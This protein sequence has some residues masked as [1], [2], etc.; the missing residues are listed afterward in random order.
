MDRGAD[1]VG[2]GGLSRTG[3][4]GRSGDRFAPGAE[5]WLWVCVIGCSCLLPYLS[6]NFLS[7]LGWVHLLKATTTT[8]KFKD[9]LPL[10][11]HCFPFGCGKDARQMGGKGGVI[12]FK[13]L[14]FAVPC[15]LGSPVKE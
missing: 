12:G 3:I 7:P 10:P 6:G 5:A 2:M 4:P 13:R 11:L 14:N 9:L 8:T 15:P 1:Y